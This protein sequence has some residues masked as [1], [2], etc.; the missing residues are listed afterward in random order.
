MQALRGA[1]CLSR[2]KEI[3]FRV[4]S[5]GHHVSPMM[6]TWHERL[7]WLSR[8]ARRPRWSLRDRIPFFCQ[9]APLWTAPRDH[10]PPTTTNRQPPTATHRQPTTAAN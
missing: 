3:G 6:Q 4:L 9:G 10:Q 2:A 1:M 5:K 8:V 7:P